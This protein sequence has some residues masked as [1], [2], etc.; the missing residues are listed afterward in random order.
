[1]IYFDNSATTRPLDEVIALVCGSMGDCY[2]NASSLHALGLTAERRLKRAAE[3]LAASV[4]CP[5]DSV[6]FTSGGTESINMAIKGYLA[7]NPRK[8]KHIV[9]SEGEHPAVLESIRSMVARGYEATLL[10]LDNNGCIDMNRLSKAIR[11]DTALISLIHV[12]NETGAIHSPDEVARIRDARNPDTAIHWDC[13][14]SFGKISTAFIGD[15]CEMASVSA[16]KIHGPKGIGALFI[17]KGT[18]VE[19]LLHGGGQQRGLRS[20]TENLPLAEGMALAAKYAVER[21]PRTESI[22]REVR[23]RLLAGISGQAEYRL[24]SPED[25]F[26]GILC[27]AFP[28]IP[29]EAMLHAMESEGIIISAGSACSSRKRKT[30]A[31]LKSMGVDDSVSASAVRFSFSFQNTT[32]EADAAAKAVLRVLARYT[33]RSKRTR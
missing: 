20:G 24:L 27:I 7:A 33:V 23:N 13:V 15:G 9:S 22:V 12:N 28:D 1:M 29:A 2:G 21:M 5:P 11:P 31:V 26:P 6:L 8:G 18:K 30:S 4:P 19:A 3:M 10:P 17:R 16:H 14:Q 32:E 25:A